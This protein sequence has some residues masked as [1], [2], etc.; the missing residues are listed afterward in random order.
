MTKKLLFSITRK[1]FEITYFS[2]TGAGGQHRNKHMNC[3]RIKHKDSGAI[4][5]CQ[6]SKSKDDN[7]KIALKKLTTTPVFRVWHA[8]RVMEYDGLDEKVDNMM[9]DENLIIEARENGKWV[10]NH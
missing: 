10:E 4:A 9:K 2:G 7:L 6:E 1:D 8:K 5:S 3:V